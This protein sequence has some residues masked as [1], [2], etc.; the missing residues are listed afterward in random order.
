MLTVRMP[1]WHGGGGQIWRVSVVLKVVWQREQE[2]IKG[3]S[4]VHM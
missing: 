4:P 2:A 1:L 3:L